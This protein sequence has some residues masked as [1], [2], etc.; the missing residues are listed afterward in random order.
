MYTFSKRVYTEA[1]YLTIDDDDEAIAN[2]RRRVSDDHTDVKV[3]NDRS[4]DSSG[5]DKQLG[6]DTEN[7]FDVILTRKVLHDTRTGAIQKLLFGLTALQ[8]DD[9]FILSE[10]TCTRGHPYKLFYRVIQLMS[11]SI[12]LPPYRKNVEL[13]ASWHRFL[14]YWFIQAR[15]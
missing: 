6:S 13:I 4:V 3:V 11:A 9:F 12:F 8:S 1:S 7:G 14:Q 15:I 2:K 5:T 10:S